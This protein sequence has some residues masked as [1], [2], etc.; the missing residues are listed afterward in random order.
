METIDGNKVISA[1]E[2]L[3][4]TLKSLANGEMLQSLSFQFRISD[5]A[6][7]CIVKEVCNAI[8]KNPV[9]LYLKVLSTEEE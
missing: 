7:S 4:V 6:I 2:R 9:P 5:R 8:M 3:T 1:A